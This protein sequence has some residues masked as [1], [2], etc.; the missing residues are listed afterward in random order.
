MPLPFCHHNTE[1]PNIELTLHL[2][3]CKWVL[4]YAAA[5][6]QSNRFAV[7]YSSVA[8][9]NGVTMGFH[10]ALLHTHTQI[11]TKETKPTSTEKRMFI[12]LLSIAQILGLLGISL[13]CLR[14]CCICDK[15]AFAWTELTIPFIIFRHIR[16]L[17]Q[18]LIFDSG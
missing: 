6:C 17:R 10:I 3:L 18:S 5:V 9:I 2:S 11:T 7:S 8:S 13:H 12:E 16:W 14:F 4:L 15:S 1:N